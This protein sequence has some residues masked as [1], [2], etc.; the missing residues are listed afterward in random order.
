MPDAAFPEI[1]VPP[2]FGPPGT[3]SPGAPGTAEN[4]P[5]EPRRRDRADALARRVNRSHTAAGCARLRR[6][7]RLDSAARKHSRDM[8]ERGVLSHTG[9]NGDS[10]GD[11]AAAEGYAKWSGELIAV[12]QRSAG[13]TVRDWRHSSGHRRIMLDCGHT[14]LG[15]GVVERGG[16]LYW[17]LEL[18]RA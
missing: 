1:P 18:G 17:T 8:A 7:A 10:P 13:E 5:S 11:R 14:E 9:G 16:R 15:T 12:G 3:A 2:A 4:G 6:D